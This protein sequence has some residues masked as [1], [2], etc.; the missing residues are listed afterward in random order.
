MEPEL[1]LRMKQL[2]TLEL[3]LEVSKENVLRLTSE[4]HLMDVLVSEMQ[5]Q[6]SRQ[7]HVMDL[8]RQELYQLEVRGKERDIYIYIY[9]EE[10]R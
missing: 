8:K 1:A 3:E 9:P 5:G 2:S 6:L 7:E 4:K 10:V